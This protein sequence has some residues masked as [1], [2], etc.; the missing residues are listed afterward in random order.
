MA[1]NEHVVVADPA[2]NR[3]PTRWNRKAME[4][5]AAERVEN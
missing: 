1:V 4:P 2:P 3:T 5:E